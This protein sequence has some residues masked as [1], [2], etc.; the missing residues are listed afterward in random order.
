MNTGIFGFVLFFLGIKNLLSKKDMN[1][2]FEKNE[3]K[4]RRNIFFIAYSALFSLFFSAFFYGHY[5][6]FGNTLN[7]VLFPTII[8]ILIVTKRFNNENKKQILNE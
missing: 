6:S 5:P 2:I 8:A 4:K 3:F 7:S 1:I